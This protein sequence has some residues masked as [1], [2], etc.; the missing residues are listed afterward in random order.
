MTADDC[1]RCTVLKM[2]L[3]LAISALM[4]APA[5]AGTAAVDGWRGPKGCGVFPGK[6]FPT[7]LDP[8]A[9][10]AWKAEMP[11]FSIAQPVVS[12]DTVITL[13]DPA[14]VIAFDLKTGKEKW[15][16]NLDPIRLGLLPGLE[17]RA[18]ADVALREILYAAGWI[19]VGSGDGYGWRGGQEQLDA[20]FAVLSK[21]PEA[22]PHFAFSQKPTRDSKA[23]DR[24]MDDIEAY[25]RDTY[26][27]AVP[28]WKS[29]IGYTCPTP[30]V[31]ESSVY[32]FMAMNQA[33]ALDLQNGKIRWAR[34]ILPEADG[35]GRRPV[36]HRARYVASP[37]L[38]DGKLFSQTGYTVTC[39]DAATGRTIWQQQRDIA[40]GGYRCGSPL[41]LRLQPGNVDVVA[42][43][44]GKITR[45]SDGEILCEQYGPSW[46]G[47]ETGGDTALT[48]GTDTLYYY[49]G[50]NSGGD[51]LA[52]RLEPGADGKVK[53]RE[54]WRTKVKGPG[55]ASGILVGNVIIRNQVEMIRA[56][57]GEVIDD[58]RG[59]RVRGDWG[60]P[61]W[62][63]G[64]VFVVNSDKFK[65]ENQVHWTVLRVGEKGMTKISSGSMSTP[66]QPVP[67]LARW[68]PD[69]LKTCHA[70]G[71][72]KPCETGFVV[73]G[74]RVLLR[75]K[76]TLYCFGP[77]KE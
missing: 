34:M 13:A 75:T 24:A 40:G 8:A 46:C 18:E 28:G 60:S 14:W 77:G 71:D 67:Q 30:V 36:A 70:K 19:R 58:G 31:D 54:L 7:S 69:W 47:S 38:V 22:A 29:L 35:R 56:D 76:S 45:L 15:R 72:Y 66:P 65:P 25:L 42:T 9:N 53:G 62:A 52:I 49:A 43:S 2:S 23:L 44:D 12:G 74:D 41:H 11:G 59:L 61:A 39:L 26:G 27:I 5:P 73:H 16:T 17:K 48:N 6:G 3:L 21:A 68:A 1:L 37:L 4:A 57:T 33:A 51:L 10:L 55:G 32:V 63:D 64:V 50:R 20:A